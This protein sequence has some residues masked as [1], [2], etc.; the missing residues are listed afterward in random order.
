M[1]ENNLLLKAIKIYG[2]HDWKNIE[3]IVKTRGYKQCCLYY[4]N[5]YSTDKKPLNLREYWKQE[6]DE[7]LLKLMSEIKGKIDVDKD[8]D[9]NS[10]N[11]KDDQMNNI[12]NKDNQM[13]NIINK[14]NQINNIINKDNNNNNN[15][16]NINIIKNKTIKKTSS[17]HYWNEVS[18]QFP[19]FT[20]SQVYERWTYILN[21]ELNK[22]KFTKEEDAIL[23]KYLNIKGYYTGLSSHIKKELKNRSVV[24]I[25]AR[26]IGLDKKRMLLN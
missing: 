12:I 16:N 21:P 6:Q 25:R 23:I 11:I 18:K 26:L 9:N 3:K 7:L 19:Q 4:K 1:N 13:N 15:N 17:K 22:L 5:N 14:D 20:K 24:Q 8:I 2:K 10:I